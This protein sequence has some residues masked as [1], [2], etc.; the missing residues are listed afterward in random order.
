MAK[1]NAGLGS[2]VVVVG[3]PGSALVETAVRLA[4]ARRLEALRCADVYAAV[5]ALAGAAGRRLLVVGRMQDLARENGA[6]FDLAAAPVARCC[7]LLDGNRPA[8][9]EHLRPALQAGAVLIGAVSDFQGVLQDWLTR[10]PAPGTPRAARKAAPA[11]RRAPEAADAAFEDLRA[12]EA[13]LSAL[14]G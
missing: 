12:T 11:G 3:D 2:C 8:G 9:P 1:D 5:A 4:E 13:E 6:F 10:A 7:C 14:L